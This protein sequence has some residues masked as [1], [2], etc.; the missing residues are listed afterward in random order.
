MTTIKSGSSGDVA[1][2]DRNNRMF[3]RTVAQGPLEEEAHIFGNA[4]Y[5]FSGFATGG[6]NVESIY[7]QNTDTKELRITRL[8]L[9]SSADTEYDVFQQTGG[10]AAG[11]VLTYVNPKFDSSVTNSVTAFGSA[12]V[13]GSVV[14]DTLFKVTSKADV[15]EQIFLEGSIEMGT[16]DARVIAC[17]VSATVGITVIGFWVHPAG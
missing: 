6:T 10:T 8:M 14:G 11:T 5:F 4:A 16:N 15:T 7:I 1:F 17:D 13:T 12:A 3:T 2:V 9:F